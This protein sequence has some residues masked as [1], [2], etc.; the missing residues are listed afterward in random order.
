MSPTDLLFAAMLLSAPLGTHEL[1]PSVER[2][3]IVRDA[4]LHTAVEWQILDRRETRYVLAK[5][6]DFQEDLD[7]LRKRRAD[8][9]EAPKVIDATRLPDRAV[10]NDCIRFNRSFRK[11]LELRMAWEPDRADFIL[12]VINETERLYKIWDAI[13]DAKSDLHYVTTRRIALLK[14]RDLIGPAAYECG[15]TPPFV[16]DWRFARLP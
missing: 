16:P 14:L 1:A 3:P 5:P 10:I 13:R 11:N 7:F 2:W 9:A 6:D 4:I 8:L 12:E 15:P